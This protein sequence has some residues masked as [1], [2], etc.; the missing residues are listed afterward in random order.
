M[1]HMCGVS[2]PSAGEYLAV[3]SSLSR[4]ARAT[5]QSLGGVPSLAEIAETLLSLGLN[6]LIVPLSSRV[7]SPM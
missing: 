3:I 2:S 7:V 6:N 5:V 1:Y 4:Y